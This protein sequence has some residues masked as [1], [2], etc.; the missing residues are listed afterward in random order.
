MMNDNY[1]YIA[2]VK[3]TNPEKYGVMITDENGFLKE[4]KEKPKE[5]SG[6]II[7]TG[8]YKLTPEIFE[9]LEKIRKSE[10]G[11]D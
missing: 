9:I 8:L 4:I 1:C 3:H 7:N 11:E 10:R 6:D 2:G 5:F